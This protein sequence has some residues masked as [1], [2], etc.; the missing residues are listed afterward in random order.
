MYQLLVATLLLLAERG[1]AG[2]GAAPGAAKENL[3]MYIF[4][5][6]DPEFVRNL[7]FFVREAVMDDTRSDYVIVV[8]E[9]TDLGVSSSALPCGLQL[10]GR[11]I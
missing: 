10:A 11:S 9:S 5:A 4:S 7:E 6:T 8:Q 3:V 1:A 2:L